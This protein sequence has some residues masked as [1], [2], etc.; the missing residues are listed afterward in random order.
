MVRKQ[1]SIVKHGTMIYI[2]KLCG[3][4]FKIKAYSL[5]ELL[6]VITII[7]VLMVGGLSVIRYGIQK[8]QDTQRIKLAK[9]VEQIAQKTYD[10]R[11]TY[12]LRTNSGTVCR[13]ISLA[14]GSMGTTYWS[15][16]GPA[17][18]CL[19]QALKDSMEGDSIGTFLDNLDNMSLHYYA[20]SNTTQPL[21]GV[22]VLL[23]GQ[24][25][26]RSGYYRYSG[27]RTKFKSCYCTGPWINEWL[28]THSYI[29]LLLGERC[30]KI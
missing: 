22:C 16:N 2:S 24:P 21:Y 13:C 10:K 26:N 3:V 1:L 23:E 27:A 5:I 17:C 28:S 14:G 29:P 8:A 25:I 11:S 12:W 4:M 7:S 19:V 9:A 15:F 30:N 18:S 20:S 6:V